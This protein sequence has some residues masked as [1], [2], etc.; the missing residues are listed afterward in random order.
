MK[1]ES[2]TVAELKEICRNR[3]IKRY[4]KL[5]KADIISKIKYA[6]IELA[7]SNKRE[8]EEILVE[9]NERVRNLS[10]DKIREIEEKVEEAINHLPFSVRP[11][12]SVYLKCTLPNSYKYRATY[13]NIHMIRKKYIW[14]ITRIS[15]DYCEKKRYGGSSKIIICLSKAA[16]EWLTKKAVKNVEVML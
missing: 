13:T 6:D 7:I 9:T 14:I 3:G 11:G 4:S 8:V 1:Y 2:M 15:R 10:L 16:K 5:R 12:C